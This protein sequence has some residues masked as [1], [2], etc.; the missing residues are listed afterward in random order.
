MAGLVWGRTVCCAKSRLFSTTGSHWSQ[1]LEF[2]TLQPLIVHRGYFSRL[3]LA[4][5]PRVLNPAPHAV[6]NCSC[7]FL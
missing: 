4:M 5:S 6:L 1:G 2:C 7:I 3:M